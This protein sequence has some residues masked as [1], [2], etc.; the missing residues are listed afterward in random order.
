MVSAPPV[1]F[2]DFMMRD[3]ILLINKRYFQSC[4]IQI[5][6]QKILI[7]LEHY[8]EF[9]VI[10]PDLVS[11]DNSTQAEACGNDNSQLRCVLMFFLQNFTEYITLTF[12]YVKVLNS[13]ICNKHCFR[14]EFQ[15]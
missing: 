2:P 4:D 1:I 9:N 7:I 10:L 5:K 6:V 12:I 15:F 11:A 14:I 13:V 8:P 3:D